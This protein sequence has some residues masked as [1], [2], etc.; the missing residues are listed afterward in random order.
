[1]NTSS[2][3]CPCQKIQIIE[4]DDLLPTLES[5]RRKCPALKNI[6]L[7]DEFWNRFKKADQFGGR[8]LDHTHHRSI[9]LLGLE[10]GYLGKITY[11]IH[12][13]I[14]N[15]SMT[16]QDYKSSLNERW[17]FAEEG[18]ERHK[19]FK[20]FS[21]RLSELCFANNLEDNGYTIT[22][23]EAW[24]GPFDISANKNDLTFDFEVKFIGQRDNHFENIVEEVAGNPKGYSWDA[25]EANDYLLLRIYE[26]AKQ[27]E[28][29]GSSKKTSIMII[30]K[31][32]SFEFKIKEQDDW[33]KPFKKP[34]FRFYNDTN[35]FFQEQIKKY[36]HIMD[37]LEST[38][39][40]LSSIQIY[41]FEIFEFEELRFYNNP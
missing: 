26:S 13:F 24:G 36:P 38:L 2:L 21:G 31:L 32:T 4:F 29:S 30:D 28:G 12:K 27:L 8:T 9:I 41:N 7:P 17:L 1:M 19:F 25:N 14:L 18:L 34:S 11:P 3:D 35:P 15:N 23:L 10:R 22:N 16:T 37:D 33:L 6:F 20:I 39:S 40:T 5:L